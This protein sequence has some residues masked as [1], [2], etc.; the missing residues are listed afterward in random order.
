MAT[1]SGHFPKDPAPNQERKTI[2]KRKLW[3]SL[4]IRS[5]SSVRHSKFWKISISAQTSRAD[6]HEKNFGL[7]NFG[8]IFRSLPKNRLRLIFEK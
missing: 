5:K 8:L 4:Q 6:V 7:K 2:P 1:L 3:I